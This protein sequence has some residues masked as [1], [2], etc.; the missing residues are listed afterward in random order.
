MSS[1]TEDFVSQS[2]TDNKN[3]DLSFAET[4]SSNDTVSVIPP[5]QRQQLLLDETAM[6]EV[7]EGDTSQG[8]QSKEVYP[9]VHRPIKNQLYDPDFA[10]NGLPVDPYLR[11]LIQN[12]NFDGRKFEQTVSYDWK[13][14][15]CDVCLVVGHKCEL[16]ANIKMDHEKPQ[17]RRTGPKKVR[18]ELVDVYRNIATSYSD[19]LVDSEKTLLHNMAK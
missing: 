5:V 3:S 18:A 9:L 2:T 19:T 1:N 12:P 16:Q 11:M 15:F 7:V 4:E 8:A 10:A 6:K 17:R 13:P 14:L